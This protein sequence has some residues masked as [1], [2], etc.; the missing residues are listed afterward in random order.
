[1]SQPDYSWMERAAC[2]GLDMATRDRLFFPDRGNSSEAGK[3]ICLGI[4][5]F[6]YRRG[7][8]PCPVRQECLTYALSFPEGEMKG[9][10][11]GTTEVERRQFYMDRPVEVRRIGA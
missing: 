11:G 1:M 4:E 6:K 2:R 10:W 8:P 7:R 9:V 3:K 5:G